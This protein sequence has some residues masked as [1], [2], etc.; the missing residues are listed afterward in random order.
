MFRTHTPMLPCTHTHAHTRPHT[1]TP[2]ALEFSPDNPEIL[3][4]VGLLYLRL[5][6]N[7]R[8]FDFLSNA[9]A[10]DPRNPKVG[11]GL[12]LG[13]GL[14]VASDPRKPEVCACVCVCVCV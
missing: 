6:E 12:G 13:L 4:T 14:G 8:A 3:T 7:F 1:Q 9:L 5:S 2:Q 10:S 11:L